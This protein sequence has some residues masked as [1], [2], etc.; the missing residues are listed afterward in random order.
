MSEPDKP[1][2]DDAATPK[3]DDTA[4]QVDAT[5]DTSDD[6][7]PARRRVSAKTTRRLLA[8]VAVAAVVV[9]FVTIFAT[10][11]FDK[12]DDAESTGAAATGAVAGEAF[13]TAAAGTCLTWTKSDA[14][15]LHQV[16]C[17]SEHLFEVAATV[18]LSQ[19]PGAEFG[20]DSK[21]PG[22]LRFTELKD[23]HCTPAVQRYLGSKFDPNGKFSVG[24][25]N[26]GEAGWSAGERTL[27]CGLQYSG[28]SGALRPIVGTVASQDQSDVLE[29][30]TC[31]GINQNLPGDPVDCSKEHA[32]EVV[33]IVDLSAQFPGGPPSVADQDK[34]LEP[35]C[36]RTSTEYL[37]SPD[38]LRDKTLTLFWGQFDST[39]W[40]AGS[41]KINCSIG[42]GA[43]V[44][45]APIV[46]SA[47]GDIT[48]NGQAPV[49]PP[50]V[51]EGR[52]LPTPLPPG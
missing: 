18:D 9:A 35:E 36:T 22:V 38:A 28:N 27:R 20:P 52:S 4:E 29:P 34:F 26:P 40:L 23:E 48:I 44:G 17:N 45:F 2:N 30:G 14:S 47:K 32:F 21:F 43:D 33:S 1:A 46:G 50:P 5:A 51:P 3:A 49:P 24:L 7:T 6:A 19:Y 31:V 12:G 41:R 10:G 11:G 16:D 13:G 42:K 15:D 37:G 39:S 8:A 25:I